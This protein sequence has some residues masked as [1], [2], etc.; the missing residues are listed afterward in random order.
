MI[1]TGCLS[2]ISGVITAYFHYRQSSVNVPIWMYKLYHIARQNKW[3]QDVHDIPSIVNMSDEPNHS[4]ISIV[5]MTA[6]IKNCNAI[7]DEEENEE[8]EESEDIK[9]K[10]TINTDGSVRIDG[11]KV[12]LMVNKLLMLTCVFIT[13]ISMLATAFAYIAM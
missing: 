13:S 9:G 6:E 5:A 8:S 10:D 3:S 7:Q 1:L 2:V 4:N 12:A 11:K